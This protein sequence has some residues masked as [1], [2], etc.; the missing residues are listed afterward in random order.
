MQGVHE[1]KVICQGTQIRQQVG[2][3]FSGF[4]TW[5]EIPKWLGNVPRR[6]L[7]GYGWNTG[8]FL[9]VQLGQGWFVV[10]GVDMTD[11]AGTKDHQYLLGRALEMGISGGIGIIRIEV[12]TNGRFSAKASRVV[13]SKESVFA[14]QLGKAKSAK[15]KTGVLHETAP[16]Q[17]GSADR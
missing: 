11:C 14:K 10:K 9:P 4:P 3:H 2:S 15:G 13:R 12:R 1:A 6:T 5:L 16:V 8:W 7:E 17:E